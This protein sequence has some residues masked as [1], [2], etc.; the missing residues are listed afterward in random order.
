[1]KILAIECS[2]NPA[3]CAVISDGRLVCESFAAV[4][5]TH[6]RTLMPMVDAM[7]KNCDIDIADIDRLAV[8]VGPGS[9]TGLRIGIAAVKGIAAGI[10]ADCVGISTLHA[11][12]YGAKGL[13]GVICPVMDARCGQV[14]NALFY[15][16]GATLT[17]LCDDRALMCSELEKELAALKN[18][19]YAAE[20]IIFTG[21]GA[22]LCMTEFGESI[23]A[24]LA[25]AHIRSQRA[26]YVASLA[27]ACQG[28]TADELSPC[29][30]RLPQAERELQ[31]K[32]NGI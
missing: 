11:A 7:L 21:N 19:D 1:M 20:P 14:Y 22:E 23:G 16:D 29:Y 17:R 18:S 24:K 25:D 9:F 5:L 6:S 13:R 3:S 15:S 32:N 10:R 12:A 26:A 28:I 27:E 8:S 4:G 30:L 31:K 2:E